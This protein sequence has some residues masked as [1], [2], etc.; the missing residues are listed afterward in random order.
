MSR[1]VASS[2]VAA[3][4]DTPLQFEKADFANEAAATVGACVACRQQISDS[5]Y[6]V[7]GTMLCPSCKTQLETERAR[8]LPIL[9][10]IKAS[11]FGLGAAVVGAIGYGLFKKLTGYDLALISIG[12]GLLVGFA[13]RSG[14]ERRGGWVYQTLAIGLTYLSVGASG[15]YQLPEALASAGAEQQG[16]PVYAVLLGA[17]VVLAG[18]IFEMKESVISILI[19]G[20]ALFEGWK[21]NKRVPLSITGPFQIGAAASAPMTVDA[22]DVAFAGGREGG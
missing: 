2:T 12:V 19:I 15:L 16:D 3:V 8:G 5:Y 4:S 17:F 7:N 9:R 21:I 1:G 11:S 13:V 6:D 20:F 10:I 14:S 22:P 18:P